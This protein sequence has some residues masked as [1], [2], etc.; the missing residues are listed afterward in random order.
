M[1]Y[2]CYWYG[3][4]LIG[5]YTYTTL[6]D[7]TLYEA[8]ERRG[9]HKIDKEIVAKVEGGK[10][11]S[12]VDQEVFDGFEML[13]HELAKKP[14][15]RIPEL[16]REDF[17]VMLDTADELSLD[18]DELVQ[19]FGLT[20]N[21]GDDVARRTTLDKATVAEN[22]VDEEKE[23]KR[24]RRFI[25]KAE[26]K[27]KNGNQSKIFTSLKKIETVQL[28]EQVKSHYAERRAEIEND[29]DEG[30]KKYFG[31]I[32]ISKWKKNPR[33]P[34]VLLGPYSVPPTLRDA[35]M[36]MYEKVSPRGMIS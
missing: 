17:E 2:F 27:K 32:A 1:W 6:Q 13:E 28:A 21:H 23:S 16:F 18:G 12:K 34:V 4:P 7:V 25:S 19:S 15:E 8:A 26:P 11:L 35:W 3:S 10:K 14:E 24:R 31:A 9:I 33:R 22:A 5:A 20:N 29:L 36:E 30:Y